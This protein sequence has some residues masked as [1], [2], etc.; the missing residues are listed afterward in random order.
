[1][2]NSSSEE[3]FEHL[4]RSR[5]VDPVSSGSHAVVAL[6]AGPDLRGVLTVSAMIAL[7]RRHVSIA[8]AKRA[9]EEAIETGRSVVAVPMLDDARALASEMAAAGLRVAVMA[10]EEDTRAVRESLGL[11]RDEFAARYGMDVE[12]LAAWE[13]GRDVPDRAIRSYL[14]VIRHLPLAASE[15][16]E[17]SSI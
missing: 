7:V 15:A 9:I 17:T 11:T 16:L 4:A 1:M 14:R 6:R 3:R 8:A 5:A 12:A 10:H 2:T 13:E